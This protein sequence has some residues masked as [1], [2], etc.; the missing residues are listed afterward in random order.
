MTILCIMCGYYVILF[1]CLINS[2]GGNF[3]YCLCLICKMSLVAI[4]ISLIQDFFLSFTIFRPT[5][6]ESFSRQ[7][8]F[9]VSWGVTYDFVWQFF[10]VKLSINMRSEWFLSFF[11]YKYEFCPFHN[12]T[13]IEQ[14][15]RWNSFAGILG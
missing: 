15:V 11:S 9:V 13:Q 2:F 4:I 7:M 12:M 14:A 6:L 5:T 1:L 8:L 10:E 3:E